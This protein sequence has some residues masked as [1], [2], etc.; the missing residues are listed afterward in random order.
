MKKEILYRI[1]PLALTFILAGNNLIARNNL[2][3]NTQGIGITSGDTTQSAPKKKKVVNG[4]VRLQANTSS[5]IMNL[6]F[7]G[8]EN[9]HSLMDLGGELGGFIDF[10]VSRHFIIQ[11]NLI[12]FAEHQRLINETEKDRL[13]TLGLEIPIYLLGRYGNPEKGYVLFGGGP[14]TAFSLWGNMLGPSPVKNPYQHVI[15]QQD[16]GEQKFAVSDNHSGLAVCLG[17]EFPGRWQINATYQVSLS[18][19]LNIHNDHAYCYPQKITLGVAYR[20]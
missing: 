20:F 6:G 11:F 2:T 16:N 3:L 4:G 19:I 7:P 17:Y 8:H 15:G 10:N 13:L 5:F 12:L 14:Y 1:I 9:T 18:N